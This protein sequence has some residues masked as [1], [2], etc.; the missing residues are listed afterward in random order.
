MASESL[1][2][3]DQ[4]PPLIRSRTL[5]WQIVFSIA[6][7]AAFVVC[8]DGVVHTWHGWSREEYSY[9][10][11]VPLIAAAMVWY[12]GG[13]R[14]SDESRVLPSL[15]IV[16]F[17]VGALVGELGAIYTVIQYMFLGLLVSI[18]WAVFGFSELKRYWY[19]WLLLVFA[20]PLPNFF[21][22]NLSQDLQ[23]ISS[24]LGV[25]LIRILGISV[26]LEG[27]VIDLGVYKLQVVEACS[28]LR[29]L[30][31]LLAFGFV[32][33]CVFNGALWKKVILVAATVPIAIVMNSVRIAIVGV[34]VEHQGLKAADG[35]LHFFEGW[36]IFV[37]C[38]AALWAVMRLL[39]R[40]GG[41]TTLLAIPPNPQYV[42][43]DYN[44]DRGL[45]LP[46]GASV[47]ALLVLAGTSVVVGDRHERVPARQEFNSFPLFHSGWVGRERSFD[48]KVIEGL[49][50]TDYITADYRHT[51]Y[52]APVN[53]YVAYYESQ[54]KGASVHSPR[55]C[56]PG[57]GWVIE[58][59]D[60]R[61]VDLYPN[62]GGDEIPVQRVLISKG[63]SAQLVYYWF[64][65]RGRHLTNQY[66]VKWFLFWDSLTQA[67]SDG[68]LV[69]L[70]I[71]LRSDGDIDGADEQMARFMADFG[72]VW[73]RYLPGASQASMSLKSHLHFA[74]KRFTLHLPKRDEAQA[75]CQLG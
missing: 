53:L 9:G 1:G 12:G 47:L 28:G 5:Q 69:R 31:P 19:A 58:S 68:A 15:S 65:Q 13:L 27:N 63:D 10:Y 29:Y 71:P 67:R 39:A 38:L 6:V 48:S 2:A 62:A 11:F 43:W 52:A 64:E 56:I 23:L 45:I 21:Y 75:V 7:L 22:F 73:G 8:W 26:F 44:A 40:S 25:A 46:V 17:G 59:I 4:A 16:L 24:E 20:I 42:S 41:D 74:D 35:F 60:R 14:A 3:A 49:A 50:L 37:L 33:A 54:R 72:R 57:G 32:L 36:V 55:A 61:E 70:V 18:F 66:A 30:F 51:E 34:L